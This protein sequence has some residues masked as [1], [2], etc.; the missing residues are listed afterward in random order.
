MRRIIAFILVISIFFICSFNTNNIDLNDEKLISV[1][2]RGQVN[3]EQII[4]LP[5]GSNIKDVLDKVSLKDDADTGQLS[6][7]QIVYNNQIINIPAKSI[8]KLISINN[9]DID[10]LLSLPGIGNKTAEK[11]IEYRNKYGSF[12][13]I[14][15]IQNVNGIGNKKFIKIK[16][17]ISL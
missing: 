7:N 3:E 11:I 15:E 9:A 1:E 13:R 12:N 14:E 17:Y 8:N 6:L 10:E 16:E 5:L 4:N 2:V